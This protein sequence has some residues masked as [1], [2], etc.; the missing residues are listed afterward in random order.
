MLPLPLLLFQ[1]LGSAVQA[2]FP[3][4]PQPDVQVWALARVGV[5]SRAVTLA[6]QL[7][8]HPRTALSPELSLWDR[9]TRCSLPCPRPVWNSPGKRRE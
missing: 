9:G 8:C 4:L 6:A 7:G 2:P 1:S 5:H 3:Y